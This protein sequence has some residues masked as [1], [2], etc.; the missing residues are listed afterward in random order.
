MGA[1]VRQEIYLQPVEALTDADARSRLEAERDDDVLLVLL[2]AHVGEAAPLRVVVNVKKL[3]LRQPHE[4][5]FV[6]DVRAIV[7]KQRVGSD[8]ATRAFRR[9]AVAQEDY[10]LQR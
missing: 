6:L 7:V 2:D 5:T 8:R 9:V 1:L 3:G 4:E 10:P